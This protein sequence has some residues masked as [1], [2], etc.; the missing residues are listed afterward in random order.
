VPDAESTIDL[1]ESRPDPAP[2]LTQSQVLTA[3]IR[4]RGGRR[5]FVPISRSFL[6]QRHQPKG[7]PRGGPG[8]LSKFVTAH[9][10]RA[11]DLWLLLHTIA[12]TQPWDVGLPAW[13]WAT[14]LGMP[15]TAASHVFISNTWSWLEQ[16]HLVRSERDRTLRRV[17]LLDDSGSGV[18]YTHSN[19]GQSRFDYFKLPHSYWLDG[20]SGSLHLPG[21]A[22]LLI[23]LSLPKSFILPQQHG[24][25]WYGI[26]RDT[27]RRGLRELVKH[28]LLSVQITRKQAPLSPTGATEQRRY[29]LREPFR[30]LN[31]V[32]TSEVGTAGLDLGE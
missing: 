20:W 22:V 29:T 7:S 28:E 1:D 15:D 32:T 2:P 24:G 9:R 6:Q 19:A 23:A 10:K 11:L 17:Y 4:G 14:A 8:P 3:L 27:V 5:N 21:S 16:Q 13:V 30:R 26:S 31:P 12:S 18:P 25:R